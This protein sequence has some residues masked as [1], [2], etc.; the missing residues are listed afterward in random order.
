MPETVKEVNADKEKDDKRGLARGSLIRLSAIP[1][2]L[3]LVAREL[4]AREQ[5]IF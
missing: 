3:N 1:Y 4:A 5:A 2:Q